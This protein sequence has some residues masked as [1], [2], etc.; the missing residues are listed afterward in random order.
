MKASVTAAN[1]NRSFSDE[2]TFDRVY[3][4]HFPFVWRCL[5]ALGI[6][7]AAVDDAAQDVFLIVHRQLGTFR[8]QSTLR[9]WLFAILRNV[10]SNH[11]R[12]VGRGAAG[13]ESIRQAA[14]LGAPGPLEHAQNLEAA[15]FV[16]SFLAGL[17]E[18]KRAVFVLGAL[19]EMS[20]PEVAAALSIPLNTAYTRLRRARA[21]FQRALDAHRGTP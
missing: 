1:D 20:M 19:E 11:R 15:A 7:D 3:A 13:R 17:D 9:T 18:K 8:G 2:L 14:S 16:Q 10:A 4:E 5:R 12:A 21:D 6:S